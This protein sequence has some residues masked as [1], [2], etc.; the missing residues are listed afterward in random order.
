MCNS[1]FSGILTVGYKLGSII[2]SFMKGCGNIKF[3][4][5]V[6]RGRGRRGKTKRREGKREDGDKWQGLV[7]PW[8][9]QAAFSLSIE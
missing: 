6:R 7:E 3:A 8:E 5:L 4:P 2:R 9:G 1:A